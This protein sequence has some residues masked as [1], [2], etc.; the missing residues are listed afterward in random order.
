M[1]NLIWLLIFTFLIS[2]TSQIGVDIADEQGEVNIDNNVADTVTPVAQ[3]ITPANLTQD[4]QSLIQLEYTSTEQATSC[5][6]SNLVHAT[7]TVD[8]ACSAGVCQVGI[9]GEASYTGAASFDYTIVIGSTVSNTVTVNFTI[10][11]PPPSATQLVFTQ[12]PTLSKQNEAIN[13]KIIVEL[14][15][16][17]NNLFNS[18]ANVTLA[19]STGGNPLPG[20]AVL[21]GTLTVAAVAGIVVFDDIT[22]DLDLNNYQLT[23]T[24]TGLTSANSEWFN[25]V[26]ATPIARSVG[27]GNT[28]SLDTGAGTNNLTISGKTATFATAIALNIGIGD[29]I[30]YDTDSKIA[31]ITGRSSDTVFQVRNAAGADA[32][33]ITND[34][35]WSVFRAYTEVSAVT[36]VGNNTENTAFANALENFDTHGA[37]Y[38]ITTSGA[39][40]VWFVALYADAVNNQIWVE[41]WI[42]DTKN[43]VKLF[44]PSLSNEVG[45]TQRHSGVWDNTKATA[46]R[47]TYNSYQDTIRYSIRHFKVEGLQLQITGTHS[48]SSCVKSINADN[49]VVDVEVSNNIMRSGGGGGAHSGFYGDSNDSP[50]GVFKV[51][52]N[53]FYDLESYAFLSYSNNSAVFYVSNNTIVNVNNGIGRYEGI[54]IAKNNLAQTCT[55]ACFGGSFDASSSNN[56]SNNADAPGTSS[57]NVSINFENEAG[58]DFHLAVTDTDAI[59]K[60]VNLASDANYGYTFDIDGNFKATSW[61]IGADQ[62]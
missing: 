47:V 8:C 20:T 39:N 17:S 54:V 61:D 2:C 46:E 29:A 3:N 48:N 32:L 53:I 9:T 57:Q 6:I 14:R 26:G 10:D 45:E 4:S 5:S 11:P 25:I 22:L 23:A 18:N 33:S 36:S 60:G 15:D 28:S 59:A 42:T 27:Y 21:G 41:D 52:H 19:L 50:G 13:P 44:A 51:H 38:D 12:Q 49:I 7:S 16:I 34:S 58:D 43:Y 35:T 24:S 30:Q 31:F 62:R 56:I 55:T 1:K 40:E 37:T